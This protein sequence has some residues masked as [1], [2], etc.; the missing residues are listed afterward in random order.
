MTPP[1]YLTARRNLTTH[2]RNESAATEEDDRG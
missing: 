1:T 2:P